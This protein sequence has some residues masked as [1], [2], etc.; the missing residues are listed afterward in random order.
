MDGV[1]TKK[2][3]GDMNTMQHDNAF[4]VTQP[5]RRI[6]R[7]E[8]TKQAKS[9][10]MARGIIRAI[11]GADL[12]ENLFVQPDIWLQSGNYEENK[13]HHR[14]YYEPFSPCLGNRSM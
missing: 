5:G 1:V 12:K 7:V 14:S 11:M 8:T 4:L 2:R 13:N 6:F 3:N 9:A 10:M